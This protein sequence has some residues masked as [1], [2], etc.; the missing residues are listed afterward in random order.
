MQKVKSNLE[1]VKPKEKIIL[2][3]IMLSTIVAQFDV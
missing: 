3:D 2:H 1:K